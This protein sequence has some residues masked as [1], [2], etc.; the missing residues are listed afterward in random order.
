MTPSRKLP[1]YAEQ[2]ER[3]LIV[4][5]G[6][7]LGITAIV[8]GYIGLLYLPILGTE[9]KG[10]FFAILFLGAALLTGRFAYRLLFNIKRQDGG[11]LHPAAIFVGT[12]VMAASSIL[13]AFINR[14]AS[15]GEI[16]L[17]VFGGLFTLVA[18]LKLIKWRERKNET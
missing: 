6:I 17:A 9:A 12:W 14:G 2:T 1:A 18:G 3:W 5:V 7:A 11:L 15:T 4:A 16:G 10:S 8:C 13:V